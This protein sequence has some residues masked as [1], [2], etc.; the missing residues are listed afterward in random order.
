MNAA[1]QYN[2]ELLNFKR[3]CLDPAADEFIASQF[4]NVEGKI[5]LKTWLDQLN[6]NS[7]LYLK[8]RKQ[9]AVPETYQHAKLISDASTLPDWAEPRLMQQ[10]ASFF[11]QHAE[12]IMNLLGLLSLPYCYAAADGAM[13]LYLSERIRNETGK[14][15]TETAEFIW[16]V[17]SP[18]AFDKLGRGFSSILKVRL[19]HSAARY[20]TLASGKWQDNWGLPLNQ[21]DMAGTNL[22]FSLIVI[23]GLRKLGYTIKYEDQAAFIHLWNVIGY[24]LGV[25]Q[26]LLPESGKQAQ[27]LEA[28]IRKRQFK[29]SEQGRLLTQAL[30]EYL[31][32]TLKDE[33]VTEQQVLG[34]MRFLLGDEVAEILDLKASKLST[35]Q[36]WL[37]KTV[38]LIKN[39]SYH[40]ALRT[41]KLQKRIS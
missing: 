9:H 13:V 2:D 38:Y 29:V 20:Y 4:S 23:R 24:L 34:F 17:M 1:T 28:A 21:E 26:D 27:L 41:F 5:K 6:N 12:A 33:S 11:G 18:A 32:S 31:S 7:Q 14:R 25:Q 15:L 40:E 30:T 22:A 3:T 16:D 36:L 39:S 8:E 10:G 19:M 37:L 35:S